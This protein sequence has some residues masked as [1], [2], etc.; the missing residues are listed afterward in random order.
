M[1]DQAETPKRIRRV[2]K[3]RFPIML[4][5]IRVSADQSQ[6][7][8]DYCDQHDATQADAVRDGLELLFRQDARRR[9][10][11]ASEPAQSSSQ[12]GSATA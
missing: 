11:E 6:R 8:G 7:L 2:R 5:G 12:D 4:T 1:S 9:E 3:S 10:R